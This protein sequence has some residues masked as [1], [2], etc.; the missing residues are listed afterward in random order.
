VGGTESAEAPVSAGLMPKI[1]ARCGAAFQPRSPN[2]K[3]CGAECRRAV[4][5]ARKAK[6]G[7]GKAAKQLDRYVVVNRAAAEEIALA[8]KETRR[9]AGW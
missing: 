4:N 7:R 5:L 3:Y 2:A 6:S 1:C 8:R 9:R